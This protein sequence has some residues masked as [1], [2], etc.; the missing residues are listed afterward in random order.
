MLSF[1]FFAF[2]IIFCHHMLPLFWQLTSYLAIYV[3]VWHLTSSYL[4]IIWQYFFYIWHHIL[5][6]IVTILLTFDFI[7]CHYVLPFS[8]HLTSYLA[9]ICYHFLDIWHHV[10][11]FYVT[12][13]LT[14][15][16]ISY[17]YM[18]PFLLHLNLYLVVIS[19][20]FQSFN[21]VVCRKN[22]NWYDEN[23]LC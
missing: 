3:T 15:D 17:H 4:A 10:I 16:I 22:W 8:W 6:L 13:F 19:Y 1:I 2:D 21:R 18:S 23:R 14:V 5:S 9:I 12:I 7:F 11:P 20:L